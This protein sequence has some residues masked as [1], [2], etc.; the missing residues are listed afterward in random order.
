MKVLVT[1]AAGFIGSHLSEAL[2][3]AGHQVV[4]VDC[5]TD[6]YARALK[7]SNLAAA[8]SR[9]EYRFI[10]A[11]LRS[12]DL[13]PV[14]DGVEVVV[15]LAATPGLVLSWEDFDAYQSCNVVAVHRLINA[16]TRAG[17]RL[18]VQASTSS[19]YGATAT[20]DETRPTRPV[21]PYGVTKLAAEHLLG[22]HHETFGFPVVILRYFSIYG[23]R[24]RPDMAYRIFAER[25]LRGEQITVYG[26]GLQTRGNT[27]VDDC[28]GAT[29]AAVERGTPGDVLNI[30]GGEP[31]AL[32]RAVE[33]LARALHVDPVIEHLPARAG[34]QRDT[35]ADTTRAQAVLGWTPLVGPE[36]GLSR[37]A[38]WMRA[39]TPS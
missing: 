22:A 27:Y 30:G 24:Q 18:F 7:E 25:L 1:G 20:G 5:F 2:L 13:G 36:E 9:V 31:V 4:G 28:V 38:D 10:E 19:V 12:A 34:D 29:I 39:R 37:F 3:A 11:D 33:L 14:L 23:P 15:N 26:D 21:S 8:T 32:L 6:Y 17:V 35:I 16:C